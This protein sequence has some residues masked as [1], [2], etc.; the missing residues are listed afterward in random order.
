VAQALDYGG[1]R[2]QGGGG[3]GV[4]GV[5]FGGT[6]EGKLVNMPQ[7]PLADANGNIRLPDTDL[8]LEMTNLLIAQRGYQANVTVASRAR[9][10]YKQALSIGNI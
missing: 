2:S 10:T 6:P 5:V 3:V 7:H 9:D 4:S 1:D 8:T